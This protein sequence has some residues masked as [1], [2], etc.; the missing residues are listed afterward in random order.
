[1]VVANAVVIAR[2]AVTA[3]VISVV[4]T[5]V[6]IK[7]ASAPFKPRCADTRVLKRDSVMQ[8]DRYMTANVGLLLRTTARLPP[9][10]LRTFRKAFVKPCESANRKRRNANRESAGTTPDASVIG[11][12][13]FRGRRGEEFYAGACL[14][15]DPN[16]IPRPRGRAE[17]AQPLALLFHSYD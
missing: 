14:A 9:S 13:P 3:V 2:V 17:R 12:R 15:R 7:L 1:S 11:E 6:V 10:G 16:P 4:A 8:R 5:T